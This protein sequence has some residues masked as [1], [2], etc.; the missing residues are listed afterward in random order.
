VGRI[1]QHAPVPGFPVVVQDHL[2]VE[3]L[4]IHACA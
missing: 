3:L 1:G 4:A 2:L